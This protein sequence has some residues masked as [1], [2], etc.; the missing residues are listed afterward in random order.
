MPSGRQMVADFGCAGPHIDAA[1]CG[2]DDNG[3]KSRFRG[4]IQKYKITVALDIAEL[5]GL[6]AVGLL[7]YGR[8][9]GGVDFG[10]RNVA[11]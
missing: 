1:D 2:F 8:P 9:Q 5:R 10:R 6:A 3:G 4:S 7:G 11:V